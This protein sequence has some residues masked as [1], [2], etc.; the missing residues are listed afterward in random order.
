MN[1]KFMLMRKVK[2]RCVV[3]EEAFLPN[4][5][6]NPFRPSSRIKEK[7]SVGC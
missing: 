6:L 7:T 4:L 5:A 1:R 2:G 3:V